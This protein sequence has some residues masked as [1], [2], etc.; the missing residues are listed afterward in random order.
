MGAPGGIVG[1]G[2]E[3]DEC[4]SEPWAQEE[5]NAQ[6]TLVQPQLATVFKDEE[7]AKLPLPGMAE[8]S[9]CAS[10]S[11]SLVCGSTSRGNI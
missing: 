4:L 3:D 9:L 2:T 1:Q 6:P 11:N 8:Y 7:G 5:P 10:S